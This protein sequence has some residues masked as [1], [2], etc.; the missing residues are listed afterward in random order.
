MSSGCQPKRAA[1][2]FASS[3]EG[4]SRWIQVSPSWWSSASR[5]CRVATSAP[6]GCPTRR[7]RMRGRLGIC[8]EGVVG[9]QHG[10]VRILPRRT[11]GS[12]QSDPALPRTTWTGGET[13]EGMRTRSLKRVVLAGGLVA[14]ALVL[15]APLGAAKKTGYLVTNIVSNSPAVPAA[16]HDA[17]L[18]NAWGLTASSSSPFWV[19]D[20]GAGVSTLYN[21]NTGT[22][23]ALTVAVGGGPT[24]TVFNIAGGTTFPV[25]PVPPASTGAS[26]RFLFAS[27]DG[28]IR[29][30]PGAG[31]AQVT[32]AQSSEPGAIYKGLA[33]AVTTAGPRLS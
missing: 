2:W 22:K 21:G 28:K 32:A 14:I 33:I 6:T 18:V 11:C 3:C 8:T 17:S 4:A 19:A 15:A 26:S 16:L 30:W 1:S 25:P 23:V 13:E 31:A 7:V 20:N 29:G 24:G 27:E 5:G 10:H 12:R 9:R